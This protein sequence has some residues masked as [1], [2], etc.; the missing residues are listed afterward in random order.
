MNVENDI[1]D[2]IEIIW[3]RSADLALVADKTVPPH[4]ILVNFEDK[5]GLHML[6]QR[7]GV[8]KEAFAAALKSAV[9]QTDAK[10][11]IMV[12]EAWMSTQ[13]A[14]GEKKI[15]GKWPYMEEV[16]VFNPPIDTYCLSWVSADGEAGI[17]TKTIRTAED[18]KRTLDDSTLM[19][20]PALG[21]RIL[22]GIFA[23][24]VVH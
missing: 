18:G 5:D 21:N 17:E 9:A 22:D 16:P 24:S 3:K 7:E 19:K 12:N 14:G 13:A 6:V 2:I 4:A 11:V 15:A 1:A 10:F 8:S 23:P 20:V